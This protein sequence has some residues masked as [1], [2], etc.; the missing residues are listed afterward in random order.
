MRSQIIR[1]IKSLLRVLE[2]HPVSIDIN[3]LNEKS[4]L[5]QVKAL[6]TGGAKGIGKAISKKIISSGGEV[7]I[8]GR[9]IEA[10]KATCNELGTKA[11]YIQFD[12][13]KFERYDAFFDSILQICPQ[14]NSMILNAGISLHEESL[15]KVSLESFDAQINTNFK[16]NYFLTQKY[17]TRIKK[18]NIIFISS[19]TADMKCVL[20]YGLTKAAINSFVAALNCKYYKTGIR[21]NAIAPGVTLTNMVRN[22]N[23]T[24]HDYFYYNNIA[25]RYFL[26]EE[27]AEIVAFLLSDVSKCISGEIIHTNVGNH[28]RAQ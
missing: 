10:L 21:V 26:P 16:S 13:N 25:D 17:I 18:G 2:S 19:E 4:Q 3:I 22:T 9:D 20:P 6:V 28:Y 15:E 11:S 14:I 27:V 24:N 5:Q 8:T 23:I 1:I 7:I 12:C